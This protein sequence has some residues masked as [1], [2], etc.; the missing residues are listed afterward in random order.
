MVGIVEKALEAGISVVNGLHE[1][2]TDNPVF[3]KL[4]EEKTWNS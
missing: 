2:L 1:Y 3:V 4:A